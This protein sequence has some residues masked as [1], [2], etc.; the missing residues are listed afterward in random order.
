M[1]SLEIY[2]NV[3]A[4]MCGFA[5]AP[6]TGIAWKL[7]LPNRMWDGTLLDIKYYQVPVDLKKVQATNLN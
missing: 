4:V 1:F 5:I 7:Q 6:A 2:R 3:A